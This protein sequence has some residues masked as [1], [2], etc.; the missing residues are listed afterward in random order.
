[1]KMIEKIKQFM[2]KNLF[3][4]SKQPVLFRDLLEA[5]CLYN[6]GML[7]DPAKLNFRYRNRR[8]YA[9]Y[10]LLCF[11]VLTLFVWILHILFSKFEADLHISVIITVILTACVFIGFDYFRVW[12]R[13]LISLELIRA[14]WRVHFPYFPYEKYSQKIEIIYNEAIKLEIPRKDLE[15]YVLDRLVHGISSDK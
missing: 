11:I 15:K 4:V 10:T 3:V 5:N 1:M 6:E 12:T 7:I 2:F 9:I 13:R 8:F 14:A